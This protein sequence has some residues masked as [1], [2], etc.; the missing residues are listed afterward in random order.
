M[1]RTLRCL[2]LVAGTGVWLAATACRPSQPAA[3]TVGPPQVNLENLDRPQAVLIEVARAKVLQAPQSGDAWG[4]LGQHLDAVD[5]HPEAIRCYERAAKLDPSSPRWPYLLGLLQ[6]QNEPESGLFHLRRAVQLADVLPDAPRLRLAQAL[7]ERGEVEEARLHLER[8]LKQI[9]S[10]PAASLEMGR[11][12]LVAGNLE[13]AASALT[14]C[15]TNAYTARSAL[16]LLAQVRQRQGQSDQA[17]AFSLRAASMPRPFDWPDPY[18][19]EVLRLRVDRQQLQDQ[20]NGLLMSG[21]LPEAE[22]GLQ[23]LM[24]AFPD[25]AEGLLLLGRLRFLQRNCPEAESTL[26]RHLMVQAESLNGLI[27]LA[28]AILCQQRWQDGA[29]VLRQAIA[30]KPDFAE[31]HYNLGFALERAGDDAGARRSYEDALRCKPGYVD[32]HVALAES[33]LR[34][35]ANAQGEFHLQRALDLDPRNEKARRLRMSKTGVEGVRR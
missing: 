13:T 11:L 16:L 19:R 2:W 1:K 18:L 21:R 5:F 29:N 31:A 34:G 10:H 17:S 28:L 15:L 14:P 22:A 6:L 12:H 35:G 30:L 20:I 7:V 33:F 25:D 32:A 4:R 26:R 27:Q 9:P 24:G 23:K 8:L 3:E